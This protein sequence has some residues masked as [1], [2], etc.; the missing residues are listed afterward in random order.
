MVGGIACGPEA[1]WKAPVALN[2]QSKD[3]R[4][5][6]GS[7]VS[8]SFLP[9][10]RTGHHLHLSH[11]WYGLQRDASDHG[12]GNQHPLLPP[13][14]WHQG[15]ASPSANSHLSSRVFRQESDQLDYSS[16]SGRD[17]LPRVRFPVEVGNTDGQRPFW[18]QESLCS[19]P[20][21][22]SALIGGQLADFLSMGA[23]LG[24]RIL[25]CLSAP[26]YPV[27]PVRSEAHGVQGP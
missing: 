2:L 14:Q 10:P 15:E 26:W 8:C 13:S 16:A 19:L 22:P 21:V 3:S 17:S 25:L 20:T 9:P 12:L 5:I 24:W 18:F 11:R 4:G 7:L 6:P 27:L 1:V 23:L